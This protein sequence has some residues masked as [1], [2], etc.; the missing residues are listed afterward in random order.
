MR[1][2]NVNNVESIIESAQYSRHKEESLSSNSIRCDY[3]ALN[4]LVEKNYLDE[5]GEV[6]EAIDVFEE[7]YQLEKNNGE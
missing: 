2:E 4:D 7:W 5:N 6:R 3:D 1:S